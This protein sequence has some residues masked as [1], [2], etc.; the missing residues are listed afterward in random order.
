MKKTNI[1]ELKITSGMYER[2]LEV[3]QAW[4]ELKQA[5][6]T[7]IDIKKNLR[8]LSN[9]WVELDNAFQNEVNSDFDT[10]EIVR[11]YERREGGEDHV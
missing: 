4:N 7:M 2:A 3:E 5:E 9:R 10:F 8:T 6:D 1:S 11:E